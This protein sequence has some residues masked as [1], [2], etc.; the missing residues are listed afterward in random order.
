MQADLSA[1]WAMVS[2]HDLYTQYMCI[3]RF[4]YKDHDNALYIFSESCTLIFM[5]LLL[6]KIDSLFMYHYVKHI[7]VTNTRKDMFQL[8]FIPH[9]V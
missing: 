5:T 8:T 3:T 9:S 6:W 7:G 2:K 1:C 4:I